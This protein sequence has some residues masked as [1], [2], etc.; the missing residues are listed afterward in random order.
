MLDTYIHFVK[1]RHRTKL[2]R[3]RFIPSTFYKYYK[4]F[5][6]HLGILE[7]IKISFIFTLLIL[8]D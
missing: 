5:K 8:K 4:L 2:E 3:L 6:L 7:S 1:L